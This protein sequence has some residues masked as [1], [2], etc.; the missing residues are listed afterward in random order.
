M[1]GTP[2]NEIFVLIWFIVNTDGDEALRVSPS[3]AMMTSLYVISPDLDD[4]TGQEKVTQL[5]A[6]QEWNDHRAG[7]SPKEPSF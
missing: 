4:M 7:S 1:Q 3:R 5:A 2:D 6:T